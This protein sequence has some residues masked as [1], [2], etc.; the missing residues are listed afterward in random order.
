MTAVWLEGK[1][2][3]HGDIVGAAFAINTKSYHTPLRGTT[4][5]RVND[6]L[7]EAPPIGG[8]SNA[9]YRLILTPVEVTNN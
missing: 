2:S 8:S 5:L 1:V 4:T 9:N 3:N 7:V 6:R